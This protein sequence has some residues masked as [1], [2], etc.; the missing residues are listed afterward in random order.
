VLVIHHIVVD[1]WSLAVILNELGTHY[2]AERAGRPAFFDRL[3][4]NTRISSVGS[5]N[6]GG[7]AG[8]RL[9]DY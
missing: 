2:L 6:V 9:W 8:E 3:T 1:F 5:R 7:P 4:C